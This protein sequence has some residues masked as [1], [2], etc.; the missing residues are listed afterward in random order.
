MRYSATPGHFRWRAPRPT[1]RG[2]KVRNRYPRHFALRFPPTSHPTSARVLPTTKSA[3]A[4]LL[5]WFDSSPAANS[6]GRPSDSRTCSC[7]AGRNIRNASRGSPRY[8]TMW[9]ALLA[10]IL[11]C[12]DKPLYAKAV[13]PMAIQQARDS[14]P[15]L[16]NDATDAGQRNLQL[17]GFR[18]NRQKQSA[19]CRTGRRR[20]GRDPHFHYW[21]AR[22][23]CCQ[24][25]L[26]IV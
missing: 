5:D 22:R 17:L 14:R 24:L 11:R 12:G 18:R 15:S 23:M 3:L 1:L 10:L 4:A 9:H 6:T 2:Q 26:Q 13:S 21:S 16:A 8:L 7:R 20:L 25:Q 19:L